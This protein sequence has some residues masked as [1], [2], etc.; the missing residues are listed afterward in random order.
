MQAVGGSVLALVLLISTAQQ[1][2]GSQMTD[3]LKDIVRQDQVSALN[4]TVESARDLLR[5]SIMVL[6]VL[7]AASLVLGVFVLRRHRAARVGLTVLGIIVGLVCVLAG[8]VGWVGTLYISVS[9]FL[10]WT[11][12]ARAWFGDPVAPRGGPGLPPPGSP[13]PGSLPPGS[14]P[15][16]S[17]PPGSQPPPGSWPPYVG[18]PTG[19]RRDVDGRLP[20]PE[21]PTDPEDEHG[22]DDPR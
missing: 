13:P 1:L 21:P 5:Y 19:P 11:R 3:T 18:P 10:L 8:P 12:P 14:V 17:Q 7:C 4:L 6:S 16:G 9:L 2:N 22:A 20:P 15:P